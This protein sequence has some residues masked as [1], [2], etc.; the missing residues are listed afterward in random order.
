M[1]EPHARDVVWEHFEEF[2][3]SQTFCRGGMN[4][5]SAGCVSRFECPLGSIG[6]WDVPDGRLSPRVNRFLRN[7]SCLPSSQRSRYGA[8]VIALGR[9]GPRHGSRHETAKG[10]SAPIPLHFVRKT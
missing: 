9:V 8:R 4:A 10:A 3:N 2:D 6:G 7:Q 5:T 1:I